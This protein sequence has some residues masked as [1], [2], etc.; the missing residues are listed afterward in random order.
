MVKCKNCGADLE[1]EAQICYSCG[2][3]AGQA[4]NDQEK[5]KE[6]QPAE[7]NNVKEPEKTKTNKPIVFGIL[8]LV[9]SFTVILGIIFAIIGLKSS[10]KFGSKPGKIMSII[11][12]ILSIVVF[13]VAIVYVGLAILTIL[14]TIKALAGAGIVLI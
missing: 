1:S 6:S 2:S 3:L 12:L 5:V 7:T 9:F 14:T 10:K 8:S 4:L 11:G 13:L